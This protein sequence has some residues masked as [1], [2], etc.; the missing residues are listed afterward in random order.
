ADARAESRLR[1]GGHSEPRSHVRFSLDPSAEG[2]VRH[3]ADELHGSTAAG[4]AHPGDRPDPQAVRALRPLHG[5][6]L[7]ICAAWRRAGLAARPHL[8]DE[9]HVRARRTGELG[10]PL[11]CGP[12]PVVPVLHDDLPWRR[13]LHAPRGSCPRLHRAD[14]PTSIEGAAAAEAARRDCAVSGPFP[15]RVKGSAARTSIPEAYAAAR[16]EGAGGNAGSGAEARDSFT[17]VQRPWYGDYASR[18]E[19]AGYH[20]GGLRPAGAPTRNQ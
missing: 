17:Q 6:L 12:L 1:S 4:P 9:G 16:P 3:D 10:G 11:P 7:D 13:R 2:A 5:R 19:G 20:A 15:A 18:A 8:H 14:E